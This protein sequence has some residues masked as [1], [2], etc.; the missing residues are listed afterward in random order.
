[1]SLFSQ[2]IRVNPITYRRLQRFKELK[3]AYYS[4][5]ILLILY[6]ISL[7]A[8]LICNDRPLYVHYNQDSYFPVFFFYPEN[9]FNQSGRMTRPDYKSLNQTPVFS[10][11]K[12]NFMLFPIIPYGPT[13]I[14]KPSSVT[15]SN[16]VKIT[17][18]REARVATINI[19]KNH[20]IRRSQQA[21][22]FFNLKSS[23]PKDMSFDE[24]YEL[25]QKLK[26]VIAS[27]FDNEKSDAYS[28]KVR[29]RYGDILVRLTPFEPRSRA[30]TT[31]R[32]S[33][34]ESITKDFT[35]VWRYNP[36]TPEVNWDDSLWNQL[37]K[38]QQHQIID[39]SQRRMQGSDKTVRLE[40]DGGIY[41][42]DFEKEDV[43]FPFRPV[44]DH[45][46]GIDSAGRDVLARLLYG[47]RTS[48]NFGLLLAFAAIIV[49]TFVGAIQGYYGGKIDLIG[50]RLT[51]IWEA[52]PFL[53]VLILLGSIYGQNFLLLLVVYGIFNW[54]GISYYM[55]AE[56]LRLRTLPFVE[57]AHC[58]GIPDRK[59]VL[60]H[61]LPN[62]LVPL[63]TFFPFSLVGAI[64]TLAALDYLGFGLPP[65]TASWGELL[66]QAQ[67]QPRW[68]LILYPSLAL[69]TV[70]ILGVFVGEGIRSAFD[71][72]KFTRME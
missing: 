45:P 36:D 38:D 9:I 39:L 61:I 52:L 19:D 33:L 65:P 35:S 48:L 30:P 63:I 11:N 34:V 10:E 17:V 13:E 7:G 62:G 43:R 60:R 69:F 22:W 71:P 25:P 12:D 31:V 28:E 23:E 56:F 50:Q 32:L 41:R 3:R 6:F 2:S 51:E 14:I 16:E 53:Y 5:W 26:Q 46:L 29:G 15:A 67:E 27:R 66:A 57:A 4:F 68:W 59:I 49:G 21:G 8:E 70:M 72:R 54:I 20:I 24:H 1:M 47:L 37:D 40:N 55:R 64:G 42:I 18:K 58:L 44:Q